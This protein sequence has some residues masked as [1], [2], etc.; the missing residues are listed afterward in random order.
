MTSQAQPFAKFTRGGF[1]FSSKSR[2]TA[3]IA[4]NDDDWYIPYNGPY[5]APREIPNRRKLRDSWGDPVV[6]DDDED[7][8]LNDRELYLRY[9][10]YHNYGAEEERKGRSRDRTLSITSGQTVSSASADPSRQ[11]ISTYRPS[12]VSAGNRPNVQ[13]YISLDAVGGVGESPI[14]RRISKEGN[15]IS[16][17]GIF[18]FSPQPRK[19]STH[20]PASGDRVVPPSFMR[21]ASLLHRSNT[22]TAYDNERVYN[23][24]DPPERYSPSP[25][26]HVNPPMKDK[27]QQLHHQVTLQT[28]RL[29]SESTED[30][31][32]NSYYSTLVHDQRSDSDHHYHHNHSLSPSDDLHPP[33]L[34]SS[35]HPYAL[36]IPRNN[37]ESSSTTPLIPPSNPTRLAFAAPSH[38]LSS[39]Q[40]PNFSFTRV[41]LKC[42]SSTPD[43]RK[44]AILH[45]AI[46]PNVI[47]NPNSTLQQM[48][49]PQFIYP[50]AKDRW[51]SA[52][53]WCDAL[54]FP[55]PRLKVGEGSG[56]IVSP[57]GSPLGPDFMGS[58]EMRKAGVASRVL[59]H[60]RSLVDLHESV[61]FSSS[62]RGH[63]LHA[64]S[65]VSHGHQDP[66]NFRA[67]AQLRS[68]QSTTFAQDDLALPTPVPSLANVLEQGQLLDIER[69]AWQ[70]QAQ[71]SFANK[72]SRS[73]SKTRSKSLTQSG[74]HR[75]HHT[76]TSMEYL[77]AQACLGTQNLSP[78]VPTME[79][80]MIIPPA[81]TTTSRKGSHSHNTSI[82][83][84]TS[85]S[86]K[87]HS[88]THSRGDSWS[89]SAVKMAKSVAI[90]GY[91]ESEDEVTVLKEGDLRGA[92]LEGA[93]KRDGTRVIRLADPV[94]IPVDRGLPINRSPDNSTRPTPSPS[95][96]GDQRV[97]I[98]LG[99]PPLV[100]DQRDSFYLPSHP[101][102]QGGLSFSTPGP[103]SSQTRIAGPHPSVNAGVDIPQISGNIAR[104]KLPPHLLHPYAQHG[105]VR[106]SYLDQNGLF[107]QYRSSDET[108]QQM[109]MW[110]QLSPGV[111][112]EILPSDFQYSPY[113]TE[114]AVNMSPISISSSVHIN[115]TIGVG[116]MLVGNAAPAAAAHFRTSEDSGIGNSDS[117]VAKPQVESE[118]QS[119][120]ISP[121][122]TIRKPFEYNVAPPPPPSE[123]SSKALQQQQQ[124]K[125]TFTNRVLSASPERQRAPTPVVDSIGTSTSSSPHLIQHLGSPN[126]LE[127]F[128]DLFYRP[129][130]NHPPDEAAF[131]DTPSPPTAA[132][133]RDMQQKHRTE[134]GL[135]S[136]ARELNQEFELMALERE[137]TTSGSQYDSTS[138]RQY[139]S[140]VSRRPTE[141]SLQFVFEE[142]EAGS[143]SGSSLSG[144]E[145]PAIHAFYPSNTLPEDV[146]SSRASSVI[147]RAEVEDENETAMLRLGVVESLLTPPSV[148]PD[149]RPNSYAGET[150]CATDNHHHNNNK[151]ER[152]LQP[153]L[154]VSLSSGRLRTFSGLQPPS[155]SSEATRSSYMTTSTQS[156]MSNLSDFPCPPKDNSHHISMNG[157]YFE[158]QRAVV[159]TSPLA[160][161][162]DSGS[163][164]IPEVFFGRDQDAG[165]VVK[166]SSS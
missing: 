40:V 25:D 59:A 28:D 107:A 157:A 37:A 101:Y 165:D 21:K 133:N 84:T 11:S 46:V 20:T 16:L 127:S 43:M 110:A 124:Q 103:S 75:G 15:P 69:K 36:A 99:T 56:R 22:R 161:V 44:S 97:G 144:F 52:E 115:D 77:A 91:S 156:R 125:S 68:L 111:L 160:A 82:G 113:T 57:P 24:T 106:D 8:V 136:L 2:N 18:S 62:S 152:R 108:P 142:A 128:Q 90:C 96:N 130:D 122:R 72:R 53:T 147:E 140:G 132:W 135:T 163:S 9:G 120:T 104:R 134:S 109:K 117:V 34:T 129:N 61:G 33:S 78:T 17:S 79:F 146:E 58:T 47:P 121:P 54:L 3:K 143:L 7:T 85:K 105:S 30:H 94:Y 151:N 95:D 12:T 31:Y 35:G 14:P 27:H 145:R 39:G 131:P 45:D 118:N 112:Q 60:S 92:S 123:D 26:H 32:Y 48:A 19:P 76:Q 23:K 88:R 6:L 153:P 50:K 164:R 67:G 65:S 5:E 100:D 150:D 55:R 93:L 66:H 102:T 73:L 63:P 114:E 80:N 49:T 64:S 74:R 87:S 86:S 162:G 154:H 119:Q 158:G 71:R 1:G 166:T 159:P 89:R 126:D 38:N 41:Q 148:S 42:S 51:L 155:S 138:S 139:S 70:T 149:H 98:A 4:E 137:R 116:E 83:K 81:D 141:G 29:S 13:S 10:R